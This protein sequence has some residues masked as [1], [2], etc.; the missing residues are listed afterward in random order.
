[1]DRAINKNNKIKITA[2]E[3]EYNLP[4]NLIIAKKNVIV[5]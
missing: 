5:E 2:E 1:M 3:F 4:I